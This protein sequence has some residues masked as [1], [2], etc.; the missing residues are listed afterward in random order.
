MASSPNL[1][2]EGT[3]RRTGAESIRR[4][5]RNLRISAQLSTRPASIVVQ[6]RE[7]RLFLSVKTSWSTL[8]QV[9]WHFYAS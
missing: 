3:C 1:S 8:S 9:W 6:S 2:L 5:V 4:L 7:M